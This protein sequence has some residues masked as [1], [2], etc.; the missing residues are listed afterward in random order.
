MIDKSNMGAIIDLDQHK[1]ILLKQLDYIDSFCKKN[2]IR[3]F[4]TGGTLLGAVRHK[5]FI[6][7]D[8]DIDIAMPREDYNKFVSIFNRESDSFYK[9]Y[10]Y[11][12]TKKY[13]YQFAKV[14]DT[15]T[16]MIEEEVNAEIELGAYI[17]VFPLDYGGDTVEEAF[18][19]HS[20][21]MKPWIILNS[22]KLMDKQKKRSIHKQIA[23]N[24]LKLLT[25][26]IPWSA[27]LKRIDKI[28]QINIDRKDSKYCGAL[29][30]LT[31]GKREIMETEWYS[32]SV[33]L[34]FE[35]HYYNAP[36]NYTEILSHLYGE[37]MELPPEEERVSHHNFVLCWR[38]G[39]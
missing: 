27:I 15:R 14:C 25:S 30:I 39:Y 2:N 29:I 9:V 20:K 19:I 35:D 22:I 21:K 32:S 10:H 34:P 28:A 1:H 31:Y 13:Y 18:S 7:W 24:C 26:L 17:D 4:I 36:S 33:V 23:V 5:G 12:N 11:S 3:Y 37:Y 38:K 6:P 8:D 16:I